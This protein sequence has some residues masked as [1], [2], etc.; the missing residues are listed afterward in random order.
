MTIRG[1]A[2]PG[3]RPIHLEPDL[4]V[5]PRF[6]IQVRGEPD[7]AF[8]V[9]LTVVLDVEAKRFVVDE[10]TASKRHP[11]PEITGEML[12][13]VRVQ[14]YMR[15][16]FQG[17]VGVVAADGNLLLRETEMVARTDRLQL[18]EDVTTLGT[19]RWVA[20]VY[21]VAALRSEPPAKSVAERLGLNQRT[22]T[23]WIA[24]ARQEGL[25]T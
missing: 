23:R 6:T 18:P 5:V 12:R 9:R 11:G 25:L 22:A 21:R 19:L 2:D 4:S 20:R 10:V 7:L 8:D 3:T 1:Y 24:R 14:D 15:K 17:L 13:A 16:G